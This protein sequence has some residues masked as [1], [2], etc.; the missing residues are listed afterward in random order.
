M[1]ILLLVYLNIYILYRNHRLIKKKID[2]PI[3]V[4]LKIYIMCKPIEL[5]KHNR[6]ITLSLNDFLPGGVLYN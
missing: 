5:V 2:L 4:I 1:I 3:I 6:S